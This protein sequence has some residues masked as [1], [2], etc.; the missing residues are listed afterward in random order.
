MEHS[1]I[2]DDNHTYFKNGLAER[3]YQVSSAFFISKELSG[4]KKVEF[5]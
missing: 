3:I 2:Y 4:G 1:D 5:D